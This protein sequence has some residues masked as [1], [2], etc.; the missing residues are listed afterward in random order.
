MPFFP[1]FKRASRD[2][3]KSKGTKD[4]SRSISTS[5]STSRNDSRNNANIS[6]SQPVEAQ[7][8]S[9]ADFAAAGGDTESPRGP[10]PGAGALKPANND[11]APPVTVEAGA[12]TSGGHNYNP[13][14]VSQQQTAGDEDLIGTGT[15][16]GNRERRY[17]TR[18][19][20]QG[21]LSR[22]M[23]ISN[24]SGTNRPGISGISGISGTSGISNDNDSSAAG[25]NSI[26]SSIPLRG[27]AARTPTHS[28]ASGEQQHPPAFSSLGSK[29]RRSKSTRQTQLPPRPQ[30]L[31]NSATRAAAVSNP[32]KEKA[33]KKDSSFPRDCLSISPDPHITPD[34]PRRQTIPSIVHIRP[35][36][37]PPP[38]SSSL[39][40]PDLTLTQ[41]SFQS[42]VTRESGLA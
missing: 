35:R 33:T 6:S 37:F 36:R 7:A 2:G 26:S 21:F 19:L 30:S 24:N 9:D 22:S 40:S 1:F 4:N 10:G 14:T 29:L 23:R 15:V 3:K 41:L 38:P 39:S 42:L 34:F 31:Q 18:D 28:S 13:S 20:L 8:V 27:N 16:T 25:A 5:T 12:G 11:S 32:R 17:S